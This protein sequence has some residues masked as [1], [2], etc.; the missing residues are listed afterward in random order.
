[1]IKIYC[2]K[3]F[4]NYFS[5]NVKLNKSQERSINDWSAHLV[6]F[7]KKPRLF[8]INHKTFFY[9]IIDVVDVMEIENINV[10]FIKGLCLEINKT[11]KLTQEEQVLINEKLNIISFYDKSTD[12]EVNNILRNFISF[13]KN[14]ESSEGV[15][16]DDFYSKD[17]FY[18]EDSTQR[19]INQ[20][21]KKNSTSN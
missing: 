20:F 6:K 18:N 7:D 3:S 14:H 21:F 8:F 12:K 4:S 5:L 16:F 13:F 11:Y 1:M 19:F 9:F 15:S 17:D 10:K 2:Y